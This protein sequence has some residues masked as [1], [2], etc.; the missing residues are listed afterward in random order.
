MFSLSLPLMLCLCAPLAYANDAA[1]TETEDAKK[2]AGSQE[3]RA[4]QFTSSIEKV[5]DVSH[6][7]PLTLLYLYS[8]HTQF[9]LF[10][11]AG[12]GVHCPVRRPRRCS[13]MSPMVRS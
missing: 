10:S 7:P 4:L 1:E 2:S 11:M 12:T 6:Q 8:S 5:K 9:S 13:P 3:P